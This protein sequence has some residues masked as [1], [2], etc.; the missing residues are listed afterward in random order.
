[1]VLV[2]SRNPVGNRQ[3][4]EEPWEVGR[5]CDVFVLLHDNQISHVD[6]HFT[7]QGWKGL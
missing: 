5:V 6:I 7:R 1:M 3:T 4:F 2:E